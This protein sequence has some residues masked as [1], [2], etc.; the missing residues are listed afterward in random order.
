MLVFMVVFGGRHHRGNRV[1]RQVPRTAVGRRACRGGCLAR[2]GERAR[3]PQGHP[4]SAATP[5]AEIELRGVPAEARRPLGRVQPGPPRRS[6]PWIAGRRAHRCPARTVAAVLIAL[7]VAVDR[8]GCCGRALSHRRRPPRIL[9]CSSVAR[10]RA[11]IFLNR[12]ATLSGA[13]VHWRSRN[14]AAGAMMGGSRA[15][16]AG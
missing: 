2:A 5:P 7:L 6:A 10:R 1:S 13:V 4:P 15:W 11:V 14:T 16:A 8:R 3:V 9:T 12:A